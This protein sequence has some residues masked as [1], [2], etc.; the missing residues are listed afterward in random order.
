M[1]STFD[2]PVTV[3]PEPSGLAL[4][5]LAMAVAIRAWSRQRAAA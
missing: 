4:A 5:G 2:L 1:S 3:V